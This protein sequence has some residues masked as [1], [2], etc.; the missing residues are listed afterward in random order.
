MIRE[1]KENLI[2]PVLA[3]SEVSYNQ[4]SLRKAVSHHKLIR[5]KLKPPIGCP[6]SPEHYYHFLFDVVV[7]L[8]CLILN[9]Q[10]NARFIVGECGIFNDLLPLIFPGRIIPQDSLNGEQKITE[11]KLVGMNPRAIH[12]DQSLLDQ[13]KKS[14]SASLGADLSGAQ[15]KILLIERIAPAKFYTSEEARVKGAGSERRSIPNHEELRHYLQTR[16]K[17]PFVLENVQLEKMSLKQQVE[18]FDQAAL[19]IGQHGAGLANLLWSRQSTHVIELL[20]RPNLNYFEK[21]S[22]YKKL[23]YHV[24]RTYHNHEPVNIPHFTE[25]ISQSSALHSYFDFLGINRIRPD[26]SLD[27]KGELIP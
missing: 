9:S 19:V 17:P 20:H 15:N 3:R 27:I 7:P 14:I 12:Y 16:V 13:L 10:S 22:R 18:M 2:K 25:W 24:Y 11:M 8:Q 4:M 21:L 5:L 6:G 1:I 26:H 23:P